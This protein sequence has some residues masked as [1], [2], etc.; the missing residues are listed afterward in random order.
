[1]TDEEYYQEYG[2]WP[3]LEEQ[4]R[5]EENRKDQRWFRKTTLKPL[6]LQ[7]AKICRELGYTDIED[8]RNA[9]IKNRVLTMAA[10]MNEFRS[11]QHQARHVAIR[12]LEALGLETPPPKAIVTCKCCGQDIRQMD[13]I[14]KAIEMV[15]PS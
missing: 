13:D 11:K 5:R 10:I 6:G 14:D 3:S 15:K 8:V 9:M 4:E 12:I 2:Y 1:M 7:T